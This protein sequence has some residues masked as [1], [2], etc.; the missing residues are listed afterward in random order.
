MLQR[1]PQR[2]ADLRVALNISDPANAA[3]YFGPRGRVVESATDGGAEHIETLSQRYLGGPY[4]WFGGRDQIRKI[5][6][7]SVEKIN[8]ALRL[9]PRGRPNREYA[10]GHRAAG[11]VVF[12]RRPEPP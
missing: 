4:P 5:L 10:V 11:L 1:I 6:T 2:Y 3:R 12:D 8:P 7:I 9:S